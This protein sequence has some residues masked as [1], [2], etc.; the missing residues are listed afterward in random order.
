MRASL[1]QLFKVHTLQPIAIYTL[2]QPPFSP[3]TTLSKRGGVHL[4]SKKWR[5]LYYE[6]LEGQSEH[7][8]QSFSVGRIFSLDFLS[9]AALW[10][11]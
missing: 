1:I 10:M 2:Q 6:V 11:D 9:Q 3:W 7:I 5:D 8:A 4:D